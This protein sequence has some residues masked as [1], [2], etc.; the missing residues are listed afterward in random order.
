MTIDIGLLLLQDGI[1]VGAIYVLLALAV[2]LVFTTTRVLFLPQGEF[3][4]FGALSLAAF[5]QGQMP[6]VAVLVV[7]LAGVAFF[8]N[9]AQAL[10]TRNFDG[11]AKSALY[12]AGLPIAIAALALWAAPFKPPMAIRIVL[13]IALV[14]PL[15]PLL[16]ELA[17]RRVSGAPVLVLL[18][19]AVAL[20]F[21]LQGAGLIMFG[22]EGTRTQPITDWAWQNEIMV[23]SGQ[24]IIIVIAS[25][26]IAGGFYLLFAHTRTGR[27]LRATAVNR[28][29]ARLM[30]IQPERSGQLAF[31]LAAILGGISGVL[32]SPTTTIYYDS[33]FGIGLKGF[34]GAVIGGL[35]SYP[36]AALGALGL[37]LLE[38][39]SSF[40]ASAF[41]EV[42]V[43]TA[44]IP[45]LL[46]LSLK[47][48]AQHEEG[49]FGLVEKARLGTAA[50]VRLVWG[51][52]AL[53]LLVAPL[54]LGE[55]QVTMLNYI[56]LSSLVALGCV[57]L[58][59]IAGMTSFGQAAFV[60]IGAYATGYLSTASGMSPWL[61]L[62]LALGVTLA[63]SLL[64]GLLTLRLSGHFLPLGTMAWS[65][66]LYHLFGNMD[67]LGGQTGMSGIPPLV[68]AGRPITD[69][70]EFYYLC[71]AIVVVALISLRWL[72]DSRPGR[73]I[74]MLN[75]APLA[76]AAFGAQLTRYRISV[77]VIAALLAAVSGWLYAHMVRFVNPSPFSLNASIEYLFMAVVGGAGNLLGALLGSGAMTTLKLW[78]Q[79][80]LPRITS[81][82]SSI[83]IIVFGIGVIALLQFT[84]QG[85]VGWLAALLPLSSRPVLPS[86]AGAGALP[87]RV[88]QSLASPQQSLATPLLQVSGARKEFGG[89]VAVKDVSF[90]VNAGEVLGLLGPNGAGKSTLFNILT[91]VLPATSGKVIYAGKE[92]QGLSPPQ[93]ARLG[94]ARTFQHVQLHPGLSVLENVAVGA[95]LR[96]RGGIL[97]AMLRLDRS[98]ERALFVEAM[99]H[100]ERV[101]LEQL[102]LRP[103]GTLALGQQRLVEVARALASDPAVLLLDEPA[104]GLRAHEKESLARVLAR[105]RDD[106]MAVVL[107]EHDMPFVMSLADR[108]V[109]INFGE[110]IASGSPTEVQANPVV[111]EA[112]LGAA[113]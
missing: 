21:V 79:D 53:A 60:G 22:P 7:L 93:I 38:S 12:T 69:S 13:S 34:V 75:A 95:Y 74:R 54:V 31:L 56:A 63:C 24:S 88:Q 11:L 14:A 29:G 45:A 10:R 46:W 35:A 109:V 52:G 61:A 2:V 59:G 47:R 18:I 36:V 85:I 5:E 90:A 92:I 20:H 39:F 87:R 102:A 9:A 86:T 96:G 67:W 76:A 94:I 43:F 77:F 89:L 16:Y 49:D 42:I 97:R 8:I 27:A 4:C 15:G 80:I 78:L 1:S 32:I 111:Q 112:Y 105:L 83:E 25:A 81:V 40:W 66:S 68:L 110:H 113:A 3:I 19:V 100:L 44:L 101:G 57:L 70:R 73:S 41:K 58:T 23:V 30:G 48:P 108:L 28:R 106:G 71:W 37:G 91:G 26:L 50:Q 62:C 103:A 33:G 99:R 65:L 51:I 55:F 98:S 107:V 84:S 64:I 72:L 82:G 104:A 6:A 17:F